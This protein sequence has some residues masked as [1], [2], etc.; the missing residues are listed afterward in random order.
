MSVIDPKVVWVYIDIKHLPLF[1]GYML[2]WCIRAYWFY[3]YSLLRQTFK[4]LRVGNVFESFMNIFKGLIYA[5]RMVVQ[6]LEKERT[7]ALRAYSHL[8]GF[9]L[10]Y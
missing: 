5:Q 1:K 3:Y 10:N 4:T 8:A 6:N 2:G 9:P 7:L